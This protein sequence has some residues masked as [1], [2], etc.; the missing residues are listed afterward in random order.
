MLEVRCEDGWRMFQGWRWPAPWSDPALKGEHPTER[1]KEQLR[2]LTPP[3]AF[4]FFCFTPKLTWCSGA[5]STT[6]CSLWQHFWWLWAAEE[7]SRGE[8]RIAAAPAAQVEAAVVVV[9]AA[10]AAAAVAEVVATITATDA[11]IRSSMA[12]APTRSSYLRET[13]PEGAPAG[14]RKPV[15]RS[16]T[17]TLSRGTLRRPSQSFPARRSS[18]SSTLWRIIPSG[19]RR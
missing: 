4:F 12:S 7:G 6:T 11:S 5:T 9:A 17:P 19:Y 3:A 2:E 16:R 10:A 15:A 14:R 18:S 8:G 1:K 13:A